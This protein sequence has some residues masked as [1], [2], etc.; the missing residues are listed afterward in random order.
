MSERISDMTNAG[1]LTGAELVPVVQ[2]G[3]NRKTTVADIQGGGGLVYGSPTT[4]IVTDGDGE[5]SILDVSV[6]LPAKADRSALRFTF[7]ATVAG[8]ASKKGKG[9]S[10]IDS[11]VDNGSGEYQLHTTDANTFADG[12]WVTVSGTGGGADGTWQIAV[13]DDHTF[14][15][16]GST[17]APGSAGGTVVST[18]GTV[19]INVY[20]DGI[21]AATGESIPAGTG[22]PEPTLITLIGVVDGTTDFVMGGGGTGLS[23]GS[24]APSVT[25]G[26][27]FTTTQPLDI[28]ATA[29]FGASITVYVGTGE[30]L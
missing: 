6:T 8:V 2:S 25:T 11:I 5:T 12:Q 18:V 19:T 13:I 22:G 23:S 26:F 24:V 20:V 21:L 14:D 10:T 30:N 15:L 17:Y 27:D 1:P 7:F 9:D 4:I 16:L 3:N 29:T 28:T